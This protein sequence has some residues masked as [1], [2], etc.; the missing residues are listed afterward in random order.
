MPSSVVQSSAQIL[1]VY[2]ALYGKAPSYALFAD[3]KATV[4]SSSTVTFA[5]QLASG[6][7]NLAG[8]DLATLVLS[9]LG[10]NDPVLATSFGQL[11]DAYG[12][13][14]RGQILVNVT[15]LL[16]G[17]ENDSKYGAV[18]KSFNAAT[19][20]NFAYASSPAN[21]VPSS[22][23][24]ITA[25]PTYTI[26]TS[27]D[28]A[29]A[30]KFT[31]IPAYTPGGN[32]FV[33]TL[34]DEDTLS[35][36]G[37]NPTLS[38]TLGQV[39]DAARTVITPKLVGISTVNIEATGS[40]NGIN[41]QDSSGLTTLTV[42]RITQPNAT[43]NLKDLPASATTY[44]LNNATNGGI[45]NFLSKEEVLTGTAETLAVNVNNVRVSALNLNEGGDGGA[46]Q[47][48]YFETVNFTATGT[49]D[50]DAMTI[51]A[52]G[53][54]D[55]VAGVAADTT[56][57][58]LNIVAGASAG[59]AGSLEIN[60]LN[61]TGVDNMSIVANHVVDIALDKAAALASTDGLNAPDLETLTITGGAN[62]RID[63]LEGQV[64][65]VADAK[66]L[67]VSAGTMTGNLRVGVVGSTSAD[68]LFLLTSGSGNDEIRTF[69]DLGGDVI[70]QAGN[71][72]VSIN[73]GASNLTA[74][75]YVSTGEGN[76]TVT[77]GAVAALA[78]PESAG[79]QSF[80][81]ALAGYIE[82]GAGNDT[83]TVTD[84][85]SATDYSNGASLLA[86]WDDLVYVKGAVIDAGAGDDKI[87]FATAAERQPIGTP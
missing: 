37:T 9:N 70:T 22:P 60:T 31:S 44:N 12:L 61:A 82:T 86:Q 6:F 43:L 32:N 38:V 64:G 77:G 17:L 73:A 14:N 1:N 65:S 5:Q 81:Q 28:T 10:I 71:D 79:N 2:Q 54:E 74:Y 59:A 72:I 33:N 34:Q 20:A 63:G 62:V 45:A 69:G 40:A 25:D 75:G 27:P 53:R 19:D 18:A 85:Q 23:N 30:N 84:V 46:D 39:N 68:D 67:L 83:I 42:N 16:A 35:G 21:T 15:S 51:Q 66:G 55:V 41:F 49:N 24:T 56:K 8:S 26:T 80:G 29:S 13:A 3:Y 87:T 4:N 36:V 50:I 47:G 57:Q 78:D 11:L 58:K 76:D 52:N 7:K 48:F